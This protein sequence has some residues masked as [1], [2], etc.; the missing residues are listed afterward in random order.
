MRSW[1]ASG[2]TKS[3][4]SGASPGRRARVVQDRLTRKSALRSRKRATSVPLPTPPGPEM[5][6]INDGRASGS[7]DLEEGLLLL[8]AEAAHAAGVG[9]P[10]LLHRATRLDLAHAGEGL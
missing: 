9:D 1:N 8:L 4:A 5:T 3:Y 6:T 7:E 10:D 2:V